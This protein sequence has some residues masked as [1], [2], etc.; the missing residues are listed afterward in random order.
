M[1]G[2]LAALASIVVAIAW[3]FWPAVS[4]DFLNWDDDAV[5]LRNPSLDFPGAVS[6]ALS[7]THME[8]YQPVSW[9]TWAAIKRVFGLDARAFHLANLIAHLVCVVL[10]W[11]VMRAVLARVM[12]DQ[13]G[14]ERDM[15][16]LAGAALF[17]LHPLRVEVVA[18]ISALPYALALALMLASLLAYLTAAGRRNFW[19]VAAVLLYAASLAARP[20]ALGYPVVVWVLDRWVSGRSMR[21]SA[22]NALPFAILAGAAAVLETAARAAAVNPTP[23]LFR[24]QAAVF[25]PFI[26]IW[27]TLAPIDLTPLDV[28]PLAPQVRI[29]PFVAGLLAL[30]VVSVAAWRWRSLA[31][32]WATYLALLFPAAGLV[33]SGLQVTADRYSYV[34][35]VAMAVAF[36]AAGARWVGGRRHRKVVAIATF[37]VLAAASAAVT[38]RTLA[39]WSDSVTLWSRVVELNP[40]NDVGLYNL[41]GAL[42]EKGR[43]DQAA[44]HYRDLLAHHPEHVQARANLA[45]L[46]AAR[47]EGEANALAARGELAKAAERYREAITLDPQRTHA[48]AARGM[49]LAALGRSSEAASSLREAVRQGA[50]EPSVHNAL[51]VLL[52]QAGQASEARAVLDAAVAR[53]PN[54]VALTHSLARLL[55]TTSGKQSDAALALRLAR[56]VVD[57]TGG[58]DPRVLDTLA[59]AQAAN[60]RRQEA[61]ATSARAAALAEAQGD[62]DL[63]VQITAR[64]REYRRPGQ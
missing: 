11:Q 21:S 22:A 52:L 19:W 12:A 10:L 15:M 47:L 26:Y 46:D 28:V 3:I 39:H 36:A 4:F 31:A 63:A 55:A 9:L 56:A 14:R 38:R 6:W 35:G 41:A 30:T 42:A 53:H 59:A 16:A 62:H 24:L 20:V 13:P 34:P 64:G 7:T 5:L 2:R 33:A 27:H 23:W 44:A 54:D 40:T 50:D 51:A 8:H 57:A 32:I 17:G 18:W 61:A 43:S 37:I 29:A 60:G 58:R 45:R 25:A 49:A 1:T 48:H